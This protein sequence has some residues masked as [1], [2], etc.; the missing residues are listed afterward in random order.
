MNAHYKGGVNNYF[1][2]NHTKYLAQ[3]CVAI[4]GTKLYRCTALNY[5]S[6]I[7]YKSL[8]YLYDVVCTNFSA[9]FWT[10]R[11]FRTQFRENCGAT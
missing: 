5:Y 2:S 3:H 9:N 11:N 1:N 7:F 8:R 6:G 10:F 4:C